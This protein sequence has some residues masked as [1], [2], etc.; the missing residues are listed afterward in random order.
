MKSSLIYS[1]HLSSRGFWGGIL[2]YREHSPVHVHASPN[3]DPPGPRPAP[4]GVEWMEDQMNN[5]DVRG[6]Q[7]NQGIAIIYRSLIKWAIKKWTRSVFIL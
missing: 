2:I 1:K 6:T 3:R 7:V 5:M 4:E